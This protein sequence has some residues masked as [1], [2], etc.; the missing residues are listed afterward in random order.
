VDIGSRA[1]S[2]QWQFTSAKILQSTKHAWNK[3]G[4][5]WSQKWLRYHSP[6]GYLGVTGVRGQ[7]QKESNRTMGNSPRRWCRARAY[8]D[9]THTLELEHATL[10][11]SRSTL[12]LRDPFT[13]SWANI[14]FW[15]NIANFFL[16]V[17]RSIVWIFLFLFTNLIFYIKIWQIPKEIY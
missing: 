12:S 11:I 15:P 9:I 14:H 16:S 5:A 10:S 8:I 1:D 3:E 17:Q 7:R 2:G 13:R 4:V 6:E